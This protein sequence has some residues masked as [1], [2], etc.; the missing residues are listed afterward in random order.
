MLV[1]FQPYLLVFTID[2]VNDGQTDGPTNELFMR[3]YIALNDLSARL[4]MIR[5]LYYGTFPRNRE[6][7]SQFPKIQIDIDI[8]I[9]FELTPTIA[10]I[11]P[12]KTSQYSCCH[13]SR[14][15]FYLFFFLHL[16][17]NNLITI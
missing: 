6:K 9:Q 4:E 8:C 13:Y 17:E 7:N 15:D 3:E 2:R 10:M 5:T 12:N 16:I 14:P 11:R 1:Q